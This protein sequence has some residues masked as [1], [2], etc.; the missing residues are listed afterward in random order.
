MK[1]ILIMKVT[2]ITTILFLLLFA[3]S[4]KGQSTTF[5]YLLSTQMDEIFM[6]IV[7]TADGSIYF[8]GDLSTIEH[9][10][11]KTSLI[12]K[13]DNN[14]VLID[15]NI[16]TY[17]NKSLFV[18]R[19]LSVD[20]NNFVVVASVFDTIGWNT[21]SGI[22]LYNMDEDLNLTNQT[23]YCFDTVYS[24]IDIYAYLEPDSNIM[25]SIALHIPPQNPKTSIYEFNSNFDS[26]RAKY[27]PDGARII[28]SFKHLS[29]GNYWMLN[30]L[31]GQYELYDSALNII[32]EQDIPDW[33]KGNQS[34]V[35]DTD[36]SFYL[37]G[38]A[39]HSSPPHNLG[40]IKQFHP[41]DTTGHI[42]NHWNISDT[43]DYPA[44]WGGID[45]N[46]KDSIFIG[47]TRN[48]WGS[49]YNRWP[50]WFIILQTDSLL[51]I[52]WERFYGGD[53][54]Y[55]MGKLIA[56]NDGGCLVA[57]T[58]YDYLNTTDLE[59]D[60][61]ILKLNS[62]GLITSNPGKPSVEMHEA[63]VYPNPGTSVINVRIAI[64]YK[65]SVFEL[66][67]INGRHILKENFVGTLGTV[68]TTFLEQ[69]TYIYRIT[70]DD[71]LFETGKW[72][73]Q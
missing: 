19:L 34:V 72:V 47:G 51:N 48:M 52:R 67:D 36:S 22:V 57:G 70:S 39:T 45:F 4:T 35:W 37:V 5:E 25:T 6:E 32:D 14:G 53:A 55:M 56:T 58:R 18:H 50:S 3:Q 68:N 54:Y 1:N 41:M 61:I 49:Y 29:D 43:V 10:Y 42:Y 44:F 64:Q 40:F 11:Y 28:N 23:I 69:G 27:Y 62:E 26:L 2:A 15:S 66:F 8:S 46:N 7:E 12:A 60:I 9:P 30:M 38:K 65:Q 13:L 63:I 17:P 59:T 31:L 33:L 71:G 21:K 73:K 24:L 20:S 16:L